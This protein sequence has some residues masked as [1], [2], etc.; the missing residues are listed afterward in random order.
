MQMLRRERLDMN[1]C[2]IVREG[3]ER[4]NGPTRYVEVRQIMV[5]RTQ[6]EWL[7]EILADDRVA[8]NKHKINM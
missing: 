7:G 6:V 4:R 5:L 8:Q 3:G 1:C 2:I